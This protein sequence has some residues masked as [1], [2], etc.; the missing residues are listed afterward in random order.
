MGGWTVY[1]PICG[2]T[3][4]TADVKIYRDHKE[5][6]E[7]SDRY[8]L[9]KEDY[10][11]LETVCILLQNG[12]ISSTGTCS[13]PSPVTCYDE[14]G[15]K[16]LYNNTPKFSF[17]KN[18]EGGIMIHSICLD[19]LKETI[20]L[21]NLT[22]KQTFEWLY[23]NTHYNRMLLENYDYGFISERQKQDYE[24]FKGEEWVT[25]RPDNVSNIK[26]RMRIMNIINYI[27]SNIK[28]DSYRLENKSYW[29][30]NKDI[31]K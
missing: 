21:N 28:L 16:I 27:V 19:L 7:P 10:D 2:L 8:D 14:N 3:P 26:N 22:L 31:D 30:K 12:D 23:K 29:I 5:N 15:N 4:I 24:L 13:W 18:K 6:N 17:D 9:P 20:I 11:F 25:K 1:C